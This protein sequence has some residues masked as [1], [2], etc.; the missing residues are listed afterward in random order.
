MLEK[1]NDP[2]LK[3]IRDIE[4][5]SESN[6]FLNENNLLNFEI[7][8]YKNLFHKEYKPEG[9]SLHRNVRHGLR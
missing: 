7:I 2:E 6:F 9:G 4:A 8:A 1:L 3:K 5:K